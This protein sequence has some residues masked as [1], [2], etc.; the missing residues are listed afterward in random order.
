M[1]ALKM[2]EEELKN[3]VAKDFFQDFDTTKI[4]GNIDFCVKQE[5]NLFNDEKNFNKKSNSN[6][7]LWAEAK[8]GNKKD[9]YESFIQLILTIGKDRTYE[10]E[11]PP[12]YLGAFDA[13][14]IAFLPFEQIRFI[15]SQSDFNW[16]VTPSNHNTKE[17]KQLYAF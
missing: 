6:T 10:K 8:A 4:I 7:L 5:K 3:K 13:Q 15:F 17:F 12:E 2:K 1:Y 16:N 11:L 9:I 14:K